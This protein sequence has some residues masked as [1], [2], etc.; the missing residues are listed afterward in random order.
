MKKIFAIL[1]GLVLAVS[2]LPTKSQAAAGIFPSGGGTKTAGQTFKVNVVASGGTFNA[3]QGTISVSGPVSVLSVV[4]GSAD[5]WMSKPSNGGTFSGALLGRTA[6]SLTIATLSIKGTSVGSGSV[7]V[8]GVSLLNGST[9][10][11]NSGGSTS[12]TIQKAPDL[13]DAITVTSDT[14]PSPEESYEATTINLSWNKESGV[15]G[16]SYLLDQIDSTAPPSKTTST[17]TSTSIANLTVGVHYFHIRAHK[18]D[19]WG[20]TTHFKINIKEPDAKINETLNPPYDI[21][22]KK[23][24]GYIND[25]ETGMVTGLT[26][27]GKT[28]PG[29]DA[30]IILSPTPELPEGKLLTTK[31]NL[32]GEF[33]LAIDFPIKSGFYTLTV[34]GQLEKVL[35]PLSKKI[36]FEISHVKGGEINIITEDDTNEPE[37]LAIVKGSFL[38]KEYP[39]MYYLVFS[40]VLAIIILSI[41][42]TIKIIKRKKQSF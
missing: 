33:S 38:Q 30:N 14:H 4:A 18:A 6:T 28:E 37:G 8:S 22:I 34:Q 32:D 42:E 11:S 24:L 3:F 35:T 27:N 10:I 20:S 39:L 7:S 5:T 41:I 25:I 12:F 19:G 15:D 13:P 21:E 23:G 29:Y 2:M 31:T 1:M 16:F 26:I 40:L 17:E 9:T 36:A